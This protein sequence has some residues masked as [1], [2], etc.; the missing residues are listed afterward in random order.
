MPDQFP[1]SQWQDNDDGLSPLDVATQVAVPEFDGRIITVPFSF[2]EIDDEGLISY[3]ADPERCARVAGLAVRHARLRAV[4]P[5][6]KRVAVVF[7]AY[8]DQ[9]R[10]HRQ[11]RRAGHP[12]ERGRA[13]ARHARRR[14]RRSATSPASTR[15]T[16]TR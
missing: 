2:K 11:R 4:A 8:P 9:A 16:A 13:A 7:S 5:Q 12:G 6:D 3:V 1:R 10:P 14:L 15:R